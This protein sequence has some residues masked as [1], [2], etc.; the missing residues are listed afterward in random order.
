[1]SSPPTIST[2]GSYPAEGSRTAYQARLFLP[3]IAIST[4]VAI[5]LPDIQRLFDASVTESAWLVTLYLAGMAICQPV[6]GRIGDLY[7]SR[8]VFHFGLIWFGYVNGA[9]AAVRQSHH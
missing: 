2:S 3:A 1:M 8:R 9:R 5:A 6:G 7:G 4:M